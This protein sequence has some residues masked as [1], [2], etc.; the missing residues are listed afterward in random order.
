MRV[1]FY[2]TLRA[3]AGGKTVEVDLPASTPA[4]TVLKTATNT[5]PELDAEI[6]L[7]PRQP[8]E[9]IRVFI[10]GRQSL[11]LPLQLET[12]LAPNDVLDIFPP[13]G[14]GSPRSE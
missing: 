8:K 6:W 2:A 9:H 11:F 3:I 10:N 5:R 1:N 12:P 4:W 13:V 14:G 7:A